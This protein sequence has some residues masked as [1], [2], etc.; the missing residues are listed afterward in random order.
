MNKCVFFLVRA[1]DVN[2]GRLLNLKVLPDNLD[3]D[4]EIILTRTQSK[5]KRK[6]P[7]L[8][9]Q[10]RYISSETSFDMSGMRKTKM[11]E[12]YSRN[13]ISYDDIIANNVSLS[14]RNELQV[15]GVDIL[16]KT[17]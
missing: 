6:H 8:N 13:I 16:D 4:V 5:K 12:L 17:Q 1:K 9:E 14:Y 15:S 2:V 10:Y 11:F 7:E 3:N